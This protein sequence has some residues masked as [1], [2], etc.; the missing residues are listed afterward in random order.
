MKTYEFQRKVEE[1]YL[2]REYRPVGVSVIL[3]LEGRVLLLESAKGKDEWMFPQG[4]VELGETLEQNIEREL[5]EETGI[6][7]KSDLTDLHLGYFFKTL[8]AENARKDKRGFTK[9]KAYFFN[10]CT[11]KGNGKLTLQPEEIADYRWVYSKEAHL[12]LDKGRKE[13]AELSKEA[14]SRSPH[15]LYQ[16]L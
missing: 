8:D 7:L 13:K 9:G 11:Y 16:N 3:D 12:Y 2:K 1:L 10:S 15:L 5:F 14:L 6:S 4:G